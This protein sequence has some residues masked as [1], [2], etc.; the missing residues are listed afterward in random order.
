MTVTRAEAAQLTSTAANFDRANDALRDQLRRLMTELEV[1]H[2]QWQGAGGRSFTQVK[3]AWAA[4]QEQL[5]AALA[6]TASA[7]R[8]AASHYSATDIHAS[9]RFR[10]HQGGS[11][12]LPL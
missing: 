9:D 1:L 2:T 6:D 3:L 7:M 4:D 10:P 8:S 5:H 11:I 12:A